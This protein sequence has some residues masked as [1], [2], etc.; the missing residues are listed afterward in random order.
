M[1]ELRD[2]EA[3]IASL[4]KDIEELGR[5]CLSQN[6]RIEMNSYVRKMD[7]AVRPC[8]LGD[9]SPKVSNERSYDDVPAALLADLLTLARS[10][11]V[12]G[13]SDGE[14]KVSIHE[15]SDLVDRMLDR[16]EAHQS[17]RDI[18]EGRFEVLPFGG[19]RPMGWAAFVE[20]G[21]DILSRDDPDNGSEAPME[22]RGEWGGRQ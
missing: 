13:C 6:Q 16:C 22:W 18:E 15:V 12:W 5:L 2:L 19:A 3:S 17:D 1:K 21:R 7:G 4:G 11:V 20:E 10:L 9:S 8:R 14:D